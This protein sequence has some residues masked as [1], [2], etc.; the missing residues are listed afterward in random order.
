MTIIDITPA[1]SA[2]SPVFPGDTIFTAERTWTLGEKCPVNVSRITLSSH[3]GA[4]AD[5]PLH[6]HPRGSS[7]DALDL[8]P[9]IGPC[10]VVHIIDDEPVVEKDALEAALASTVGEIP[11]RVLIRT[12]ER[13]PLS[14]DTEFTAISAKAIEWLSLRGVKLIGVDTASL[15]PPA[16]KSM[17]AHKAIYAHDMRVLEGLKLDG[18]E[19]GLYEL[20]APP[21]KL[22]GLDAAPVR[23]LLRTVG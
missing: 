10:A 6:Y 3:S 7:I 9:Y 20:I 2:A 23:A 12:Y 14:W 11:A 16:S 15:D 1:V 22:A 4:H 19:P 21:L 5:A 13:Q 17:E 18:V 8:A